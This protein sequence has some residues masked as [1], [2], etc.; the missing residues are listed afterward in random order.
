MQGRVP[1]VL[2]YSIMSMIFSVFRRVQWSGQKIRTKKPGSPTMQATAV[3]SQSTCSNCYS[4][5][6]KSRLAIC[7][8]LFF[9]VAPILGQTPDQPANKGGNT[10][11]IG[12]PTPPISEPKTSNDPVSIS[13]VKPLDVRADVQKDWMD[14]W[15]WFFAATL[16]LIGASGVYAALKTL[17]AIER[18]AELME[19][20]ANEARDSATQQARD[21]QDSIAEATRASRAMEGI[22]ESM[23]ANVESVR[24]SVD[25]SREVADMQ[26]LA[27]ELH[28]R[29]YLS[30]VFNAAKYQDA[31]HV[32]D[33]EAALKNHG[34][35][36]AYDVTFRAVAQIVPMP[37]PEDFG[38]PLPNETTVPSV[39]LL[40]PGTTK[41]ITRS[42]AGKVPDDQVEDIK[43]GRPPR[44]LA[45]WGEVKYRDAFRKTR[46]VKFAFTI[47]WIPWVEGKGQDKDGNPLPERIM[48]Y[49]TVGHNDAD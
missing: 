43:L 29:A 37:L 1:F 3:R 8:L 30:A 35:T 32:F 34:N 16:V 38:F 5:S 6:M 4:F 39:S 7:F 46:H 18:Q 42:V 2:L 27:T 41:F 23:A 14:K 22:A 31:D 48:S 13:T 28:G 26:K 9:A 25:I 45:M 15:N 12:Q 40:A 24:I 20:Q 11:G 10:K 47:A 21:V 33:V 17:K 49:D 36:P 44:C 19:R